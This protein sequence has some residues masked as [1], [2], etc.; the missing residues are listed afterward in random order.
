MAEPED[1]SPLAAP[2]APPAG[3]PTPG[4]AGRLGTCARNDGTPSAM[5]ASPANHVFRDGIR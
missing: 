1:P 2:A 4:L 3:T 5:I